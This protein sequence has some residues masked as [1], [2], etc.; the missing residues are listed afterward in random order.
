METIIGPD[1]NPR[2][3]RFERDAK[4]IKCEC[5][6]YAE[7]VSCT[8]EELKEFNRGCP[9]QLFGDECCARAFVCC[10]CGK[11]MVGTA[12]APDMDAF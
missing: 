1:G 2:I 4:A 3:Y 12:E 11:R 5:G 7:R 6:G 9:G 10:I 8:P